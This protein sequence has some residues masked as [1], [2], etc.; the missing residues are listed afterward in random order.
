MSSFLEVSIINSNYNLGRKNYFGI[1]KKSDKI[2]LY[3]CHYNKKRKWK[4][5][6]IRIGEKRLLQN[7]FNML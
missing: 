1:G 4:F 2:E 5:K 7:S 3:L 6:I